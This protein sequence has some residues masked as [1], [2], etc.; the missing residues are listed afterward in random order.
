MKTRNI[1]NLFILWLV[2]SSCQLDLDLAPLDQRTTETFYRT[3]GDAIDALNSVYSVLQPMYGNQ[4]SAETILTPTTVAADD[5][6]PFL[7][8]NADRIALWNYRFVP[9]NSWTSGIWAVSFQAIQRANVVIERVPLIQ[10]NIELRNR[11][12]AEAKFLRAF[13]YFNLVRFYG[14][15]PL[16]LK[17]TNTLSG[18]QAPRNSREEVYAQ[19]LKDLTEAESALPRSYPDAEAGRATIGAVKGLMAKVYLTRA[20]NNQGSQ[21]WSL[22][23]TKAK[24]VIDLGIYSLY[25]EYADVFQVSSRGGR[26]NIF[27]ITYARDVF[28]Q[29]HSTY[30]APRGAP[31]VPF[32]GFGTIRVSKSLWDEFLPGDKRRNVSFLTSYVNP[33][34][35]QTVELSIDN[36]DFSR[37]ISFWKLADLSSTVFSGGAK[38]FPYMRYAEILLIYAEALNESGGG[39]NIEAFNAINEVRTRA[40]LNPLTGLSQTDFRNAVFKERRIELNFEG[41][42]WFDLVRKE[43]LI[44]AVTNESSFGRNPTIDNRHLLFPIPQREMDINQALEQNAGY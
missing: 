40:G 44:A 31:I 32:N 30:W 13:H 35:G 34:N 25:P 6:I 39:P 27:E 12:V 16:V 14:G 42:R 21:D 4:F 33:S 23:A 10:M 24:E 26:E 29:S 22:A 37:A 8:G 3:E 19:I 38:S 1:F 20:G 9:V 41:H 43:Q 36:P 18:L 15:V 7:Q 2:V 28:G 5:G 11:L 17:E